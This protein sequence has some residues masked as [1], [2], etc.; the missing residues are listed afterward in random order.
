[1]LIAALWAAPGLAQDDA[2]SEADA[3]AQ[4][5]RIAVGDEAPDFKL[6]DLDGNPH[7]LADLRG[8]KPVVL[9]FFRGAW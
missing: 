2:A 5:K 1:L 6:S 7:H 4:A 9:V 3:P 8:K